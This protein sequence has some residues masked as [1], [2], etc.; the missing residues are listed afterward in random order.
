MALHHYVRESLAYRP[1]SAGEATSHCMHATH[2]TAAH[3]ALYDVL[4][5]TPET[6]RGTSTLVGSCVMPRRK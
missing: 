1:E 6:R 5:C 3:A 2:E 4:G